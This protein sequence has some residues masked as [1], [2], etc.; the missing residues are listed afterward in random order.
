MAKALRTGRSLGRWPLGREG[1]E[2][3]RTLTDGEGARSREG[4]EQL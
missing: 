1:G 2:G 3:R 4:R